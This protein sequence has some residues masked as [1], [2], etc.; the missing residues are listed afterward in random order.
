MGLLRYINR[1]TLVVG[2]IWIVVLIGFFCSAILD[3]ERSEQA[4][5]NFQIEAIK[6]IVPDSAQLPDLEAGL[7][8]ISFW[9]TLQRAA[10]S[11]EIKDYLIVISAILVPVALL[12]AVFCGAAFGL[13]YMMKFLRIEEPRFV[14][15]YLV[16][17]LATI[18][19]GISVFLVKQAN[20]FENKVTLPF[21]HYEEG[22]PQ[23]GDYVKVSGSFISQL[24][25]DNPVQTSEIHC[26]KQRQACLELHTFF[27]ETA[28]NS[29]QV[30]YPVYKWDDEKI[31]AYNLAPLCSWYLLEIGRTTKQV[32]EIQFKKPDADKSCWA[33]REEPVKMLLTDGIKIWKHNSNLKSQE[34]PNIDPKNLTLP[35]ISYE[36]I[37]T[38]DQ[39]RASNCFS[40]LTPA[41]R[42]SVKTKGD[43][44]GLSLQKQKTFG[45]CYLTNAAKPDILKW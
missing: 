36:E 34:A 7:N 30:I 23:M 10:K 21:F 24:N 3:E 16:F 27:F 11:W 8:N 19:L 33:M 44:L 20:T 28:M 42:E 12:Y 14:I 29:D 41:E 4:Q 2:I 35:A 31:Y 25:A 37:R 6:T 17:L 26:V 39:N 43:L 5:L 38:Y 45:E 1:I 32:I 13:A 40:L 22:P 15:L 18:V 9:T